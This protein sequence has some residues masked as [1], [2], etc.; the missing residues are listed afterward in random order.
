MLIELALRIWAS[1]AGPGVT[2]VHAAASQD[3]FT[4]DEGLVVL[5]RAL[6]VQQQVA[7][8]LLALG[9]TAGWI[10]HALEQRQE[11][12]VIRPRGKFVPGHVS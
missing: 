4:L 11:R 5:C 8:G 12:F 2:S 10:A 3:H 1:A 6:G 7:S 9:R